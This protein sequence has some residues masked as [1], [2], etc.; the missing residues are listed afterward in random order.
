MEMS[1]RP[2]LSVEQLT[3]NYDKTPVLWDL[4]FQVPPGKFA[5]IIGPNGAGKSTLLKTLIGLIK[6]LSGRVEIEGKAFKEMRSRVAYVPQKTAVD[7]DFPIRVLDVV[8]MGSYG[9]LGLFKWP[10]KKEKKAAQEALEKVGML[11][12]A[13]RQI[14]A[15][16]G[17]QKQR[18]FL[19]RTL[20]QDA[21][22]Y[23][24]DEPFAGVD[25]ATE[26]AMIM[27][28]HELKS[29]GKS[30]F[31]VHHDLNTVELYFDWV[32]MLNT[33]LIANGPTQEVFHEETIG[34]AYGRSSA[35]LKEAARLFQNQ[36]S[37]KRFND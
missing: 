36:T 23:L 32:I 10:G 7:W 34:R 24:L 12:F 3:V 18:I 37:G 17:G 26:K 20:M 8:L 13:D 28:L 19:A 30:L 5:G 31:V 29:Q 2:I 22:V 16:S 35:V 21:D 27:L 15:L 25:V 11:A 1:G 9:K 4:N 14:N 6:P 33:C